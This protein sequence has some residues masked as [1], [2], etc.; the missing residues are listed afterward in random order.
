[1]TSY[2]RQDRYQLALVMQFLSHNIGCANQ[3]K[4]VGNWDGI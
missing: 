2:L 1:M 3:T 4:P